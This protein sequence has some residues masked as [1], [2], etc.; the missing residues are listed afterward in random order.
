MWL[1]ADRSDALA[2]R[3]RRFVGP[4]GCGMGGL[5]SSAEANR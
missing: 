1:T 3:R 5:E 4:A 2:A